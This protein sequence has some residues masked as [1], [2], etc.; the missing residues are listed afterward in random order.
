MSDIY[1]IISSKT[2]LNS[3]DTKKEESTYEVS[4]TTSNHSQNKSEKRFHDRRE[5]PVVFL[6]DHVFLFMYRPLP[7]C[8]MKSEKID[9]DE[10]MVCMWNCRHFEREDESPFV[11][12]HDINSVIELFKNLPSFYEVNRLIGELKYS[13]IIVVYKNDLPNRIYFSVDKEGTYPLHY[14]VDGKNHVVEICSSYKD[15]Y[16]IL[17]DGFMIELGLTDNLE[18]ER[19]KC[20]SYL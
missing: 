15:G 3:E 6:D 1:C 16:E 8:E 13:L 7:H 12:R 9:D 5:G 19:F 2:I 10:K 18:I 20:S 14:R 11:Q 17:P 4:Q